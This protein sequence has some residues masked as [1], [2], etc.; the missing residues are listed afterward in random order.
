MMH[1]T[2]K[3]R[4]LKKRCHSFRRK[5]DEKV[6]A[7]EDSKSFQTQNSFLN[8]EISKLQQLLG[9][10]K[11][12]GPNAFAAGEPMYY[13]SGL[14]IPLSIPKLTRIEND[15]NESENVKF[16]ISKIQN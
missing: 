1:L 13:I 4:K 10:P 12:N 8:P 9:S 15:R 3:Y 14:C 11:L 6:T 2:A 16:V 5:K 7:V